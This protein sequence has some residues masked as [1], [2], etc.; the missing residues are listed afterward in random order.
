VRVRVA[1]VLAA[2]AV[3]GVG[4]V[5]VA[6][7][8]GAASTLYEAEQ[9][10]ISQGVVES[11]HLGFTGTGFV[12]T[13]NTVGPYVEFSVTAAT[14]GSYSLGIRYSNGTTTSRPGTVA[15]NG[16]TV[17]TPTFGST[18]NWD[19]WAVATV[20]A[21]LLAGVNLVRVTSTNVN[22]LP[23]LDSLTVTGGPSPSPSP[24]ASSSPPP[25]T[26]WSDAMIDS[27]MKRFT[28]SSI[29][30]W[31]YPVALYMMGQYQVA[32]RTTNP[33][34]RAS[35]ISY[36][37]SWADRFVDSSGHISNSFTSLDS[38][39]PGQVMVVMYR[40][41]GL[42]KYRLAA[43]QIHDRLIPGGGYPTT[44]D[45]GFWHAD[46]S[47][48]AHQLWSDGTFMANPFMAMYGK[49]IG[50]STES[51]DI[52][53][54]QLVV[55]ASHLQRP[56]GLMIHAYDE[57]KT[58]SWADPTT[59]LSPEFWCRAIGWFGVAL[60][61][62]LDLI[63]ADHPRRAQLITILQKLVGGMA[64]YQDPNSGRWFQV[65]DKGSRTD[66]WTETSCSAMYTY[67]IDSS[68]KRGYV[69]GT[70]YQSN[71]DNGRR[72]ELNR[73]SL[74]S[75]GLTYLTTISIGTNVG[76][77]SYYINRTQA[78]NDFHGLGSFLFFYEEAYH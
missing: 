49:Y 75:D 23:N 26:D 65:V 61:Q 15:V 22:G 8:A 20:P 46:T 28:P 19:T 5:V 6:L 30:G 66:N 31:S 51:F 74:H 45:G 62:I 78:T 4:L 13:D 55:Y 36:I 2:T 71:V 25:G 60:V 7:P 72:G 41:T 53:T 40:E 16:T 32:L 52:A 37:R 17:A 9:A 27:T 63:P 38:M 59:G 35:L 34:R 12:N 3:L 70:T 1:A 47:S 69:S 14:A 21:D 50:D 64:T 73:I 18:T 76:D 48:R 77:Y 57:S 56:N 10:T 11:N 54:K 33:T 58:A 44:S 29:G 39:M 42:S 43:K 24:S 67:T 68:I